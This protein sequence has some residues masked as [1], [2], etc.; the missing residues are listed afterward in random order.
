MRIGILT[1]GGD[2]VEYVEGCA[3]ATYSNKSF[4]DLQLNI[5]FSSAYLSS[6]QEMQQPDGSFE[7]RLLVRGREGEPDG[8]VVGYRATFP[9]GDGGLPTAFRFE[10]FAPDPGWRKAEGFYRAFGEGATVSCQHAIPRDE[11]N[12]KWND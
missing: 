11:K 2:V 1:G 10:C 7:G 6:D 5:A 8:F 4:I 9:C 3:T 12:F